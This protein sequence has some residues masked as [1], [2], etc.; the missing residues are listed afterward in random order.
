MAFDTAGVGGSAPSASGAP[1]SR[2]TFYW[3]DG[4][5]VAIACVAGLVFA[6]T[7]VGPLI[8]GILSLALIYQTTLLIQGK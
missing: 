2:P 4:T 1:T 5:Y 8:F 3:T 7:R 6:D